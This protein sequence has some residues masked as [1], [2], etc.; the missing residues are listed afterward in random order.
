MSAEEEQAALL[1]LHADLED[2]AERSTRRRSERHAI[3]SHADLI[4]MWLDFDYGI[5]VGERR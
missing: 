4:A 5:K 1:R 3:E 2:L